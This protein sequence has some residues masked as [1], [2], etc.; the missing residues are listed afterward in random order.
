[1]PRPL[2]P[3]ERDGVTIVQEAG[4][5][6]GPVLSVESLAS[7]GIRLPDRPARSE[8]IFR[9]LFPGPRRSNVL[10]NLV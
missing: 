6:P 9:L 8:S 5:A 1:M 4:R 3:G 7:T 2:Y 10:I